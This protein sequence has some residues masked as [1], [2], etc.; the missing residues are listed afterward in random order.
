M[1]GPWKPP[2]HLER[3]CDAERLNRV[4]NHAAVR[5]Y[6]ADLSH[7]VI[8]MSRSAANPN[9]VVLIGE[10]GAFFLEQRMPGIYEVHTQVLPTG[11]GAWAKDFTTSGIYWMFTHTDAFEI[12]TRV[13]HG[14]IAAKALTTASG[15]RYEFTGDRT[16]RFRERDVLFDVYS[17]RIQDWCATAEGMVETGHWMHDRFHQEE[18]RLGLVPGTPEAAVATHGMHVVPH[19]DMPCHNRFVGLVYHMALGGRVEKGVAIYN[20]WAL[21]CHRPFDRLISL[22]QK[23]PPAVR[24]DKTNI[25]LLPDGDIRMDL[26]LES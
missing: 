4:L 8:D 23:T 2:V 13:P 20:R 16:M 3:D 17:F 26:P 19:V 11:R 6:V 12:L 7:G 25:H 10:H 22:V 24:F 21:A 15:L 5:P 9:N 18:Q 14:H 1:N